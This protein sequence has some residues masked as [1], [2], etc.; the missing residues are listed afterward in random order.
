[1]A[2]SRY[3]L[4]EERI[5]LEAAKHGL[6][7]KHD[8]LGSEWDLSHPEHPGIT[9]CVL[10][11]SSLFRVFYR[12][13]CLAILKAKS[14]DDAMWLFCVHLDLWEKDKAIVDPV[15]D[16]YNK[17]RRQ[18]KRWE[19]RWKEYTDRRRTKFINSLPPVDS[20]AAQD[21]CITIEFDEDRIL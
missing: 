7:I 9:L 20:Q 5:A 11:R 3:Q 4:E 14:T 13:H 12:S 19:R 1:M 6:T 17:Q 8:Y 21:L 15:A 2:K 10:D 16:A 18:L